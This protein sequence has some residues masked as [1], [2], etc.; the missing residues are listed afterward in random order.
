MRCGIYLGLPISRRL[1][2]AIQQPV[3]AHFLVVSCTWFVGL[4]CNRMW[5][6]KICSN[7]P[8]HMTMPIYGEK[9]KKSSTS[10]PRGR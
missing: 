10:E 9:L 5:G 4:V 2:E 3:P 8:G 6:M 1:K 7:I